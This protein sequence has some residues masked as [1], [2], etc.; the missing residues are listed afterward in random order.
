[1]VPVGDGPNLALQNGE[2]ENQGYQRDR[3][4]R[5]RQESLP[6][7]VYNVAQSAFEAMKWPLIIGGTILVIGG[8]HYYT[9]LA[10]RGV[11][12]NPV[13]RDVSKVIV[14]VVWTL[15]LFIVRASLL[16]L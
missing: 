14:Y 10:D 1:M 16:L 2:V 9:F 8:A 7:L 11:Y 13:L 3:A 6:K 4:L 12:V 15:F 5:A